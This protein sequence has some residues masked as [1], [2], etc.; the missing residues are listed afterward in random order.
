MAP[1]QVYERPIGEIGQ[2]AF[3]VG[4]SG[5]D[6]IGFNAIDAAGDFNSS[7]VATVTVQTAAGRAGASAEVGRRPLLYV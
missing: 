3:V 7:V 4:D 1:N 2:W 5:A 6:Q